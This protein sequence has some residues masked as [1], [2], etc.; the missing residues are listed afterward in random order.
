MEPPTHPGDI[1]AYYQAALHCL[2]HVEHRRPTGRRFGG[3]A[4]A[5]WSS[6]HGDL[7]TADRIDLLI[8]DA[9]AQ[10]PSAFSARAVFALRAVAEDEPFGA[11]WTSLDPVDAEELWRATLAVAAPDS[12]PAAVRAIA[13]AWDLTLGEFALESGTIEATDRLLVVGPGAIAAVI[14]EFAGNSDLDWAEQVACV[15]TPPAHR[16]LAAAAAALVNTTKATRLYPGPAGDDAG[17]SLA[18]PPA[19]RRRLIASPDADPAD[20]ALARQ[21]PTRQTRPPGPRVRIPDKPWP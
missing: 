8:R 19:G 10:W 15:A 3:D 9:D 11:E 7:T 17:A 2:H 1:T 12:V 16:Q 18:R 4:D 6:F 13:A 21:K 5:R 20:L 14:A